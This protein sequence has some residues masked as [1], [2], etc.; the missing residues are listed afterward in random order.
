[1]IKNIMMFRKIRKKD[2]ER[3]YEKN[4]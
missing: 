2:R 1:M 4:V 3:I